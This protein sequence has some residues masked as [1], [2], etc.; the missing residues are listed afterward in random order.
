MHGARPADPCSHVPRMLLHGAHPGATCGHVRRMLDAQC[1]APVAT[2]G[3]HTPAPP[4]ARHLQRGSG[5]ACGLATPA[6]RSTSARGNSAGSCFPLPPC[7]RAACQARQDLRSPRLRVCRLQLLTDAA[8]AEVAAAFRDPPEG[9]GSAALLR[10]EGSVLLEHS[11][12]RAAA[13]APFAAALPARHLLEA[14][15]G[16]GRFAVSCYCARGESVGGAV[17]ELEALFGLPMKLL[18]ALESHCSTAA[19]RADAGASWPA[20]LSS[21]FSALA[22]R[23]GLGASGTG[24]GGGAGVRQEAAAARQP[25]WLGWR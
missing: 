4:A 24:A 19:A 21:W 2:C 6:C 8:D 16:D 9:G 22:S 3:W 12:T 5:R 20:V 13:A 18:G 7:P 17:V 25:C 23:V 10:A 1:A 14:G 15:A 11:D